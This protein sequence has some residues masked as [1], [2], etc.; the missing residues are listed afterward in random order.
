MTFP[1]RLPRLWTETHK[2]RVTHIHPRGTLGDLLALTEGFYSLDEWDGKGYSWGE[3]INS[4]FEG[5]HGQKDTPRVSHR[6]VWGDSWGG[7]SSVSSLRQGRTMGT[8]DF[9]N[10]DSGSR[11]TQ[12]RPGEGHVGGPGPRHVPYEPDVLGC[13]VGGV[14]GGTPAKGTRAPTRPRQGQIPFEVRVLTD[15]TGT[16]HHRGPVVRPLAE[17]HSTG[18]TCDPPVRTPPRLVDVAVQPVPKSF[19]SS[20]VVSCLMSFCYRCQGGP[21]QHIPFVCK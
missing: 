11:A 3:G 20:N 12:P 1:G 2:R 21:S 14:K 17:R 4:G 6:V 7:G 18:G 9:C 8:W 13:L 10:S 16:R 15:G 5:R 19:V